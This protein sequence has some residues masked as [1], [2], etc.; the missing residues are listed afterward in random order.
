MTIPSEA[1]SF[2]KT[3]LIAPYLTG[4]PHSHRLHSPQQTRGSPVEEPPARGSPIEGPLSKR[5]PNRKK[6]RGSPKGESPDTG[7]PNRKNPKA[8]GSPK[9]ESP[10]EDPSSSSNRLPNSFHNII[11]LATNEDRLSKAWTFNSKSRLPARSSTTTS[12]SEEPVTEFSEAAHFPQNVALTNF[13]KRVASSY[14]S[15]EIQAPQKYF[16]PSSRRP[17][18]PLPPQ[19]RLPNSLIPR[20]ADPLLAFSPKQEVPKHHFPPTPY[21]SSHNFPETQAP[22]QLSLEAPT[23]PLP[24]LPRNSHNFPQTQA[25]HHN[26]PQTQTPTN[27]DPLEAP[28]PLPVLPRSSHN[29]PQTQALS[30]EAP[31][32]PLP[33]I[34]RSSYNSPRHE[35]PTRNQGKAHPLPL[36]PIPSLIPYPFLA[37]S[38]HLLSSPCL[39]FFYP[40]A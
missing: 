34:P 37:T 5:F 31:T 14:N 28:S 38:S 25:P 19:N 10:S 30:L 8:R 7:F 27:Q 9:G 13:P 20:T 4:D 2:M 12:S 36:F 18:N 33:V 16:S 6:T 40:F 17:N 26:F 32:S 21:H 15:P 23:R 24:V 22:Y 39:S 35:L 29:F 1:A 11:K 3:S